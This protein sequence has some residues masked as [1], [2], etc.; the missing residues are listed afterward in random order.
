MI[1]P[2][3]LFFFL[4]Y[5]FFSFISLAFVYFADLLLFQLPMN[6]REGYNY[7]E[8]SISLYSIP[9]NS[10][11][12]QTSLIITFKCLVSYIFWFLLKL[13]D[14]VFMVIIS[15]DLII[16]ESVIKMSIIFIPFT[17]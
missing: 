16:C 4:A 3:L 14:Y 6:I 9:N 7:E 1:F 13:T 5:T 15:S 2:K 17:L 11:I 8:N 10:F 12:F